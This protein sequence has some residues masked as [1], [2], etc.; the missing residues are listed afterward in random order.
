MSTRSTYHLF[1]LSEMAIQIYIVEDHDVMRSALVDF[2]EGETS[3]EIAGQADSAEQALE[4]LK[5]TTV[6]LALVDTR[7]PEMNGIE[8]VEK[9]TTRQSD[10][11]CMMLSGHDEEAYVEKALEAGASGYVVKGNPDEIPEAIHKVLEGEVY[12]SN[13]LSGSGSFEDGS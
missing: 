13:R 10:L 3:F 12:L 5:E 9:L 4:E 11:K 7:L 6:D 1:T 8:L 2:I